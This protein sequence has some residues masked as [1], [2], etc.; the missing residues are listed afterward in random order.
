MSVPSTTWF[1]TFNNFEDDQ[2]VHNWPDVKDAVWQHE[3]AP[4]TGTPHLQGFVRFSKPKRFSALKKI[5]KRISWSPPRDV[6]A[7]IR[8]CQ[9]DDTR[10]A[11]PWTIGSPVGQQGKRNDI[12]AGVAAMAAGKDVD[13]VIQEM[14]C[15]LRVRRHLLEHKSALQNNEAKR[16]RR[17]EKVGAALRPW[18]AEA[19]SFFE[20]EPD[21]R[22]IYWFYEADGGA[23]K[24]FFADYLFS[25]KGAC[26]FTPSKKADIALAYSKER[27]PFVV[28]DCSKT[29]LEGA[30]DNVYT[31]AEDLKNGR[32]FSP[33]YD[34]GVVYF[35]TPHVVVFSNSPPDLSKVAKERIS[36]WE[37]VGDDL[38]A[39]RPYKNMDAVHPC[40]YK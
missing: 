23:G 11:G 12:E 31:I 32:I 35:T 1:F 9:K 5:D 33:K 25:V 21:P 19:L 7:S 2:C 39:Y 4:T 20:G 37:I 40:Q 14:P 18:Q 3:I 13:I 29:I 34:S 36:A 16:Q 30:M 10:V 22:L 26:I 6:E 24:S 27:S 28:F 17:E 15:L 8:Y 38:C